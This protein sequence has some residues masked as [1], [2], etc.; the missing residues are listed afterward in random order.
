MISGGQ[1][2][3]AFGESGEGDD[4]NCLKLFQMIIGFLDV[5]I[6]MKVIYFMVEISLNFFMKI[7]KKELKL[8]DITNTV[9]IIGKIVHSRVKFKSQVSPTIPDKPNGES[10]VVSSSKILTNS[11]K[12]LN[13]MKMKIF[14]FLIILP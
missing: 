14:E 2:V 5:S 10:L 4:S 13:K 11:L 8:Q 12:T 7:Q 9:L 1:E 3:S 6:E